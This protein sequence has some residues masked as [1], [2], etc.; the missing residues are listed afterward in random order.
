MSTKRLRQ[1]AGGVRER[2]PFTKVVCQPVERFALNLSQEKFRQ[3]L[4]AFG[5]FPQ[6]S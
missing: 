5:I 3:A 2:Q 1:G 6:P 4:R